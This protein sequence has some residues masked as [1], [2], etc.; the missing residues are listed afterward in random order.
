MLGGPERFT[1]PSTERGNS[2]PLT[3]AAV[4][5]LLTAAIDAS[6]VEQARREVEPV[7]RDPRALEMWSRD[8]FHDLVRLSLSD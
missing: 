2:A 6:D 3:G 4:I 7:V 1:R 8:F 5:E